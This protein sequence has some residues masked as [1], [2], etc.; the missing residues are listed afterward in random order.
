MLSVVTDYFRG[1]QLDINNSARMDLKSV[2]IIF[3]A[4][5]L[6]GTALF[7]MGK[8][9]E[10]QQESYRHKV[11]ALQANDGAHMGTELRWFAFSA[12]DE[13]K[14]DGDWQMAWYE[15]KQQSLKT[16]AQLFETADA[17]DEKQLMGEVNKVLQTFIDLFEKQLLPQLNKNA[18]K[19]ELE[20]T[21]ALLAKQAVMLAFCMNKYMTSLQERSGDADSAYMSKFN[22]IIWL[23]VSTVLLTLGLGIR[24]I[25]E[26]RSYANT[27]GTTEC[28]LS[29]SGPGGIFAERGSGNA[30]ERIHE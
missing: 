10:L 15:L 17:A 19:N 30:Q 26:T 23:T 20:A 22:L 27:L 28:L 4:A 6:I 16:V 1:W 18:S 5:I 9:V 7:S 11:A 12:T 25:L 2:T 21:K 29:I 24:F 14:F 3:G 13:Q 8:L